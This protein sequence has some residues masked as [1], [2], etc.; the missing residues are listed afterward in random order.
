MT[1]V[2]FKV[3]VALTCGHCNNDHIMQCGH[4]KV[5]GALTCYSMITDYFCMQ[6]PVCLGMTPT[7]EELKIPHIADL[8]PSGVLA[9]MGPKTEP[10]RKRRKIDAKPPGTAA[11]EARDTPSS[12]SW[13]DFQNQILGSMKSMNDRLVKLEEGQ[14]NNERMLKQALRMLF[15]I[16]DN[17]ERNPTASKY[18]VRFR[19]NASLVSFDSDEYSSNAT[20]YDAERTEVPDIETVAHAGVE[21]ATTFLSKEKVPKIVI[22]FF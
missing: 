12:S 8:F 22:Q 13:T 17:L 10:P 15:N 6:P 14:L 20:G 1:T 7:H 3:I 21:A 4:F 9:I 19:R 2:Q 5:I 16:N 11:P 18:A